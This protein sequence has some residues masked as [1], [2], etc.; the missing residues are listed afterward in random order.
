MIMWKRLRG[1]MAMLVAAAGIFLLA[2]LT[3]QAQVTTAGISGTVKDE[4][5]ALLPGARI[6]VK[7]LETGVTRTALTDSAAFYHLPGLPPGNYEVAAEL[8]GFK[9]EVRRGIGLAVGQEAA[10]SFTLSV[11]AISETVTVAGEPP[12]VDTTSPALSGLVDDKKIRDLPLNGRNFVELAL[13]QA[14]VVSFASRSTGGL[15]GRGLQINMNGAGARSNS[16]LLDGANMKS[17]H[18]VAVSTAA[19]TSLGVETIRE[20][21]VLTSAFSAEYGRAM[22]GVINA[23][24]KSGTNEIH[25]SAFEFHRNDD[26]DASNFSDRFDPAIGRKQRPEF[27]RNQFGIT[28][29]GPIARDKTFFFGGAEWLRERLGKSIPT[30]V[31]DLDAREGRV[32]GQVVAIPPAVKPFLDLFPRPNG[33][34]LR[35]G[36]AELTFP[37][38]QD[39]DEGFYQARVDHNFSDKDSLFTRYT[40]DS[41]QRL[42]PLSFP[43]FA[44]S[45]ESGNQ[46]LTIEERRIF[47]PH[48][49][50]TFRF[51][52][53][54]L[55]LSLANVTDVGAEFAFVPGQN[56]IGTISIAGMPLFGTDRPNPQFNVRNIFTYSDDIAY[57]RGR[58]SVKAGALV[59]R[60]QDN[61][62]ISTAVR[63]IFTFLGVREFLEGRPSL[64]LGV[65]PGSQID[66]ARRN[67]LLGFYVQNDFKI[68][69]RVTL[70]LGLRYEPT[71]VS[72]DRFGRDSALRNL[73]TDR[74]FAVGPPYKNPSLRNWG[75]RFG[76][77]WDVFGNGSTALR[78]GFG[79]YYDTDATFNSALLIGTFSPPF[80][81]SVS[82]QSPV[83]PR[84]SLEVAAASQAARTVDFNIRQ[85]HALVWN[86]SLQREVVQDLVFTFGYAASRG[87]NLVR[88]MEGNSNIPRILPDGR[89]LFPGDAK[90][91]NPN[92]GSVDFRTT[93][94]NS[95]HH[96]AQ[97]SALKRYRHGFQFQVSYTFSRTIDETQGQLSFDA[98]NGSVFGTDPENRKTDRGLADFHVTHVLSFN[99][100]WDLPF[101]KNRKGV[102]GGIV[103]GWQVN[104]ITS[105]RSGTPFTPFI[106]NNWSRSGIGVDIGLGTGRDRPNLKPGRK[107]PNIVLG[108][109]DRY[110]DPAAFELPEAG[111]LG[112]AGRN[113]LFGPGLADVDFSLVKNNRAPFLGEK[114]NIQLRVEAF[115]LFNRPN[116]GIP[117]RV[118]FGGS[119]TGEQPLDTA[120][121]IKETVTSSRQ[122][123]LGLK[124]VF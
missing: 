6:T 54:R 26:L 57:V 32:E 110:F 72:R 89:K 52:F 30:T 51:S 49:L 98:T 64:F 45:Q 2:A 82:I 107:A 113:I 115:N 67:T 80:A 42:L 123:Q 108:G 84:P 97:L 90:R 96:S 93:G 117:D 23:V 36:L 69:P 120:G 118:V 116:L 24:T 13:L 74:E 39:T 101:G 10:V 22:G 28:A 11:G 47:T 124:I 1:V 41:A 61:W 55:N 16:Y 94:S 122:I 102:S 12:L 31:P 17:L 86:L 85:P 100:T 88:A 18:G 35:G 37:F 65:A 48:L 121:N 40:F 44:N 81:K 46:F 87:I 111:F 27:K 59:E 71:S 43:R 104:G 33:R 53:S 4:T 77:A 99:Y 112:N 119:T 29:G 70:N 91:R 20:F 5:G 21:R 66:R 9:I 114:G 7:N 92:L 109:P 79:V 14:G 8:S 58:Y 76:V 38:S 75:P 83:F 73:L 25:G 50:N 34:T 95:W 3:V 78:G 15:S 105:V 106:L 63:G 56:T 103:Q 19:D 68:R 62:L 60:F